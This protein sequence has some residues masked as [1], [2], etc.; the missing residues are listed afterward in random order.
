MIAW[1]KSRDFSADLPHKP[2]VPPP[3]TTSFGCFILVTLV[4]LNVQLTL[5]ILFEESAFE[6]LLDFMMYSNREEKAAPEA[7]RIQD[8]EKSERNLVYD[9]AEQEPELHLRTYV[10]VAA[11]FLLNF[12][13]VFALTG[14]PVVVGVTV[15]SIYPLMLTPS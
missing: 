4:S 2:R 8:A 3:A 5:A 12:V 9:D 1:Y 6:H 13:Q 7:V 15:L 10:A 14:P 11:M